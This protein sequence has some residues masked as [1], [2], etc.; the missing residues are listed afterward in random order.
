MTI[1]VPLQCMAAQCVVIYVSRAGH[2][3]TDFITSIIVGR[4]LLSV[5][6]KIDF[7]RDDCNL[8]QIADGLEKEYKLE[9][10]PIGTTNAPAGSQIE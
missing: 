2:P 8:S 1:A 10:W 7:G 4:A 3:Q 5:F 9:M 6:C